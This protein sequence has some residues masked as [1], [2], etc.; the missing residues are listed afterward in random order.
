MNLVR[1]LRQAATS[2][3]VPPAKGAELVRLILAFDRHLVGRG[4]VDAKPTAADSQK[5]TG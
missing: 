4:L 1:S 3:D 5:K 2:N